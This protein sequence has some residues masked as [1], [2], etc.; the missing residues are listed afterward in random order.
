M[1]RVALAAVA[2]L[3]LGAVPVASAQSLWKKVTEA[4]SSNKFAPSA[5]FNAQVSNTRGLKIVSTATAVA[6]VTGTVNCQKGFKIASSAFDYRAKKA[7]KTLKVP[8]AGGYCTVYGSIQ[9]QSSG[10]VDI[11]LYSS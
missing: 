6:H 10:S 5:N 7:T 9:L 4:K 3:V 8:V 2:L 1:R 11:V